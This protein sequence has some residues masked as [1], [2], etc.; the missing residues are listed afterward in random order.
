MA[1]VSAWQ[2]KKSSIIT[3]IKQEMHFPPYSSVNHSHIH[4]MK[5]KMKILICH[6]WLWLI[7]MH[8]NNNM[9]IESLNFNDKIFIKGEL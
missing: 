1:I 6:T 9:K 8:T 7:Y 4:T 5:Y 3:E 2:L